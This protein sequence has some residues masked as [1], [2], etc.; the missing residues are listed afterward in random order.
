MLRAPV[1]G[2]GTKA[3]PQSASTQR[4]QSGSR[5]PAST[6]GAIAP[7]NGSVPSINSLI[8]DGSRRFVAM[9]RSQY[10]SDRHAL[11]GPHPLAYGAIA[12]RRI[13]L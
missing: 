12:L 2:V 7:M 9:A 1:A 5:A 4:W 6:R 11:A 3:I 10:R 8:S 13:A